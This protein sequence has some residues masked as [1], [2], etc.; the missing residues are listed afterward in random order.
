MLSDGFHAPY[1]AKVRSRVGLRQK[2][3]HVWA[4]PRSR[5]LGAR[6]RWEIENVQADAAR[7]VNVRVVDGC[8][9]V[10]LGRLEGI[11]RRDTQSQLEATA[12]VRRPVRALDHCTSARHGLCMRRPI[13]W[14]NAARAPASRS[15]AASSFIHALIPG[16]GSRYSMS[17]SFFMRM[18]ATP[19]RAIGRSRRA[20]GNVDLH[21]YRCTTDCNYRHALQTY[22]LFFS[23]CGGPISPPRGPS[24]RLTERIV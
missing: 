24:G 17:S 23:A 8:D 5:S 6:L 14:D 10:N 3:R 7:R 13:A 11:A 15:L 20:G 4:E 21:L 1:E 18:S 19:P 16:E 9:K 12:C 22:N 2:R